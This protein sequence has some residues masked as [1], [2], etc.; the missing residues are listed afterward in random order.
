MFDKVDSCGYSH[1]GLIIKKGKNVFVVHIEYSKGD[2]FKI[3]PIEKFL[4]F[5]SKY[6][7]LRPNF[8]IDKKG[9]LNYVSKL[10]NKP[11]EFDFNLSLNNKNFYCT[12]LVDY[13]YFLS[14]HKHVYTYLYPFNEK[15]VIT[16][17]SI[18]KN[19]HFKVVL[20]KSL[21]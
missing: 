7:I 1:S 9:I 12:E 4:K 15:K 20:K 21:K 10:K 3:V 11:P 5:S 13:I 17:R 18:L 8:K 2:D 16:V 14:S 6:A 19:P